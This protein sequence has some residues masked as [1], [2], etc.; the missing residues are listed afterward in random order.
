[1]P[2]YTV[3]IGG[4]DALSKNLDRTV[5]N[6][7]SATK[8]L[9]EAGPDKIGPDEL[10]DACSDFRDDWKEGLDKIKDAIDDINEGLDKAQQGYAEMEKE[11][12]NG[13][14]KMSQDLDDTDIQ[15]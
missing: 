2:D 1:M 10:D 4:L 13:L 9:K 12:A 3:D 14:R 6:I 15:T 11:V 7:D 8:Q 5:E